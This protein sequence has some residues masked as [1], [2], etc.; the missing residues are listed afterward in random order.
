MQ[1]TEKVCLV[2]CRHV[3]PRHH[4]FRLFQMALF[5]HVTPYRSCPIPSRSPL[6]V[7]A[8]CP[9]DHPLPFLPHTLQI[10][11]Y[12]CPIPSSSCPMPSRSPLTVPAP[13]P[14]DH[15]LPFLPHALQIIPYRSSPMCSRSALTVPAPC[16]PDQPLPF[17]PHVL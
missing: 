14:P 6:T 2:V 15:P 10:T 8:P 17:L 5:L 4:G 11:P 13:C 3:S 9:P 12:P 16:P 1:L 7:P